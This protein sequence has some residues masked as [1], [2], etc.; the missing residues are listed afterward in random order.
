MFQNPMKKG[1]SSRCSKSQSTGRRRKIWRSLR[2]SKLVIHKPAA[3]IIHSTESP[4]G[5]IKKDSTIHSSLLRILLVLLL[6]PVLILL[7]DPRHVKSQASKSKAG[8][9]Q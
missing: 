9:D 4:I 5:L 1:E 2:D 8:P 3:V 6:L 7:L